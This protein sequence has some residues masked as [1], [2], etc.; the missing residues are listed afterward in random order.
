MLTKQRL[1]KS[2]SYFGELNCLLRFTSS[3]TNYRIFPRDCL[4][5]HVRY[6]ACVCFF[7]FHRTEFCSTMHCPLLYQFA[8]CANMPVSVRYKIA[9]ALFLQRV[10]LWCCVVFQTI[11]THLL[12][13]TNCDSYMI[14][15]RGNKSQNKIHKNG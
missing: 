11:R 4:A 6:G 9:F 15:F 8:H 12:D 13:T 14:G 7:F 3:T 5:A 1:S 2:M 10:E